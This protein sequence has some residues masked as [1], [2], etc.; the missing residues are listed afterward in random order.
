MNYPMMWDFIMLR[1]CDDSG[2]NPTVSGFIPCLKNET[3]NCVALF[4][5][6]SPSRYTSGK[7]INYF[8]HFPHSP[9]S[10]H[11]STPPLLHSLTPPTNP[12][13]QLLQPGDLYLVGVVLTLLLLAARQIVSKHKQHGDVPVLIHG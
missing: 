1:L 8:P 9:H 5:E 7:T 10:P 6:L 13:M 11:S 3:R 2:I 4:Q 12:P